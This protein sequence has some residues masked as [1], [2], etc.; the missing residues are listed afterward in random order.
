MLG[1]LRMSLD[2]CEAAYLC[3]SKRI[4]NPKRNKFNPLR[5]KDFLLADGKF[6]T[7]VL[8][9]AIKEIVRTKFEE[10]TLLQDPNSQCKV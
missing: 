10:S 8:E 5:S 7:Q 1:R 9:D 6:N 2:E 4:F 3:L